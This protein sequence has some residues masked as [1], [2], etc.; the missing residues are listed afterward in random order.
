[1][2]RKEFVFWLF[3]EDVLITPAV[4]SSFSDSDLDGV[5]LLLLL[6]RN[7]D[8]LLLAKALIAKVSSRCS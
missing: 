5:E 2:N 6:G 7:D 8:A 1:M 3:D 4:A